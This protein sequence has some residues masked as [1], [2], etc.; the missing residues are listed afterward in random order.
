ARCVGVR[1]S[2]EG[3]SAMLRAA[4]SI[5]IPVALF[6]P[7]AAWVGTS[8]HGSPAEQAVIAQ[9]FSM[10]RF[11]R[12][13]PGERLAFLIGLVMVPA[14]IF[15]LN[16]LWRR[17]GQPSCGTDCQSVLLKQILHWSGALLLAVGLPLACW[18]CLAAGTGSTEGRWFHL[19][20][21]LFFSHPLLTLPLFAVIM[22]ALL[23][24]RDPGRIG[25]TVSHGLA[26]ALVLL[27]GL[28]HVFDEHSLQAANIHF[29]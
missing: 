16:L 28:V 7:L 25:R 18:A 11:C 4:L 22:A 17:W 26:L 24:V 6:V 15:G 10:P 23:W 21:N 5:L 2:R 29:S 13:E 1:Q 20:R 14:G 12:P 9:Q 3:P 19:R 8:V 27:V